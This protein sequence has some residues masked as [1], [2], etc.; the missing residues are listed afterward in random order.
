MASYLLRQVPHGLDARAA[1]QEGRMPPWYRRACHCHCCENQQGD[2]CPG[3]TW[4]SQGREEGKEVHSCV[5]LF[6]L[7]KVNSIEMLSWL[8]FPTCRDPSADCYLPSLCTG[9]LIFLKMLSLMVKVITLCIQ[10]YPG[11][12]SRV[13]TPRLETTC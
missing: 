3:S 10:V 12:S 2:G 6:S 7:F 9:E 1:T 11:L 13:P 8:G 5:L 4:F